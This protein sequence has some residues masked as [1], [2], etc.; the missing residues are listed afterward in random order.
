MAI[1]FFINYRRDDASAEALLLRDALHREFGTGSVFLDTSSLKPGAI[2]PDE[3]QERLKHARVVLSVIGPDWLRAGSDEWGQHRIDCEQDW[4]RQE[5]NAALA[6]RSKRVIPVLVRGGKVPPESAL[7]E[8]I[9]DITTRQSIE[10]RRDCWD[11][12]VQILLSQLTQT[13]HEFSES[14]P[15]P[16]SLA[17]ARALPAELKE[18]VRVCQKAARGY[19][20]GITDVQR[21]VARVRPYLGRNGLVLAS[22]S[23]SEDQEKVICFDRE[24]AGLHDY[25]GT[26]EARLEPKDVAAEGLERVVVRA[27]E[28]INLL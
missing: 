1:I 7:P 8:S 25:L 13:A 14:N 18:L 3:L 19:P 10:I 2:W 27:E 26:K 12:D 11:G 9:K 16:S 22:L 5:L 21:Q 24:I 17:S 20:V 28:V 15:T 23:R 6:D 4:V